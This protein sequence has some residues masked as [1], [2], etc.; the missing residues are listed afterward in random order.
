MR[1]RSSRERCVAEVTVIERTRQ[2]AERLKQLRKRLKVRKADIIRVLGWD[3]TQ[4]YDLYERGISIIRVDR[5]DDW[6]EAFGITPLEFATVVLGIRSL[7][8][9]FPEDLPAYDMADD[10]R[11]H[12]PQDDIASLVAEQSGQ[13][14]ENR[15]A[16]ARGHKRNTA[17][18]QNRTKARNRP[19]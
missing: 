5:I 4:T 13:P 8:E 2:Q 7:D 12:I 3:S 17:R 6:A 14:D 19:A 16:A 1:A 10:L 18:A 11:G 15:Q 9:V